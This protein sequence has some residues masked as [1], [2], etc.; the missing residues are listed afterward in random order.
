[1]IEILSLFV[2]SATGDVLRADILRYLVIH[3]YGGVYFDLDTVSV[4]PLDEFVD[5]H[6]CSLVREPGEHYFIWNA[7]LLISNGALFCVPRHP[8]YKL[9]IAHIHEMGRECTSAF[10]CTGPRYLTH[11]YKRVNDTGGIIAK[12]P[13][14]LS[15]KWF[16]DVYDGNLNTWILRDKCLNETKFNGLQQFQKNICDSWKE[17]GMEKRNLSEHAFSYHT[18]YHIKPQKVTYVAENEISKIVPHV[19]IYGENL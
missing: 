3:E 19:R 7:D 1:M 16:Q 12:R 11:L 9:I 5:S 17:R 8:F 14:L 18:W 15:P 10:D 13:D 4:K 2:F 6:E